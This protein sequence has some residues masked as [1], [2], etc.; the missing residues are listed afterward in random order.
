MIRV[1][2]VLPFRS[3]TEPSREFIQYINSLTTIAEVLLVDGSPPPIYQAVDAQCIAA[4]RHCPPDDDLRTLANGKVRG[5]LTGLR[6]A[7]YEAVIVADDDVRYTP[8]G[9]DALIAMLVC[10]DV[11]RPQNYFD[12][13]PWHARLDSARSLINR[14]LGGDWPGTL[15]VRRSILRRSNGYNGNV[16]FENLELVRTVVAAGGYACCQQDLFVRRLPPPTGHFWRQRV[17]QAYDEFARPKRLLAALLL[18]P[19]FLTTALFREWLLLAAVFVLA[20][21]AVAELGRRRNRGTRVFPWTTVLWAPAWV[22]ERAICVW[23]AV[24]SRVAL[25]GV[26]YSGRIIKAAATPVRVLEAQPWS[27]SVRR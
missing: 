11:V 6:R 20:P 24:A 25:G 7:S 8:P 15:A 22:L 10:C 27:A 13:L 18:G 3:E 19:L 9:I 21:I 23:A 26:P 5:V 2:Y 12:P 4:V 14:V 17:R 1:S 16:L